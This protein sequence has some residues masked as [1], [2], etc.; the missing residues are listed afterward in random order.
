MRKLSELEEGDLLELTS[1]EKR[2]LTQKV[3]CLDMGDTIG[4]PR[5]I[6]RERCIVVSYLDLAD[7]QNV[8]RDW[9]VT[10]IDHLQLTAVARVYRQGQVI[11]E[12]AR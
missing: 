6:K 3:Q 5:F 10:D 12:R 4:H 9:H 7:D 11:W 2:L 1:G 8:P